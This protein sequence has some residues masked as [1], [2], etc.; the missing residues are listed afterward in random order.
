MTSVTRPRVPA[1]L[2]PVACALPVALIAL[3]LHRPLTGRAAVVGPVA[4]L[5]DF[6]FSIPLLWWWL[7]VKGRRASKRSLAYVF[8][9]SMLAA[10]LLVGERT[11]VAATWIGAVAVALEMVVI[12]RVALAVRAARSA[13][14]A[15]FAEHVQ[16]ATANLLGAG[17]AAR[18]VGDEVAFLGYALL[19]P[20]WRPVE[21]PGRFSHQRE[22]GRGSMVAGLLMLIALETGA[23]HAGL[24]HAHP[25]IAWTFTL[26]SLWAALWLFGDY[27]AMRLSRSTLTADA[28]ELR[29]GVRARGVVP[30]AAIVDVR[31]GRLGDLPRDRALLKAYA[32]PTEPTVLLELSEPVMA[33]SMYMP[34]RARRRIA[35]APDDRARF[36]AELEAARG[37]ATERPGPA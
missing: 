28:L 1:W 18:I 37:A 21:G 5:F 34:L 23:V 35:L 13:S 31:A 36:L 9:A 7:A 14:A 12:A 22:Q 25:R 8:V 4:A 3:L 6:T 16:A 24:V 27:Q 15:D 33:H 32:R 19:G 26:S 2:P 11:P 10:R 29:V 17:T 30:L 20:W